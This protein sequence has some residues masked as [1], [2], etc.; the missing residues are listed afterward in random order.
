MGAA[1]YEDHGAETYDGHCMVIAPVL[2][3]PKARGQ[4]WLRSADP[5][6]KPRII[7]NTLSEPDDVESLI[8]GVRL[9]REI[10]EQA[11]LKEVVV[12]EL[13][14]GAGERSSAA[15]LEADL[16]RRLMLIYHPV[17]TASMSDT[18]PEAV[19]DSQLRVHGLQ[20]LR[21]IDASIMPTIT[22]G[23]TNAPTIMI[24][25]RGADLIRDVEPHPT[26]VSLSIN[27]H[28]EGEGPPLVLLHGVGHHWQAWEPVIDRLVERV[29]RDRLRLPRL[30][31]LRAAAAGHRADDPRICRR[32][33][34][35]LR[36]ARASSARMSP[37]TRWAARSRWS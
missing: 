24:A 28:R 31:P 19:V 10:A 11:P 2:V 26:R 5:T 13:K 18:H 32:V 22:G 1:Y 4:V 20:G 33:R 25:E 27:Y 21:V 15:E 29:R 17:G 3:S 34:V 7:T 8:A 12:K 16:R 37:A 6:A 36:R 14:P 30:R 9:A 35:V 23:N